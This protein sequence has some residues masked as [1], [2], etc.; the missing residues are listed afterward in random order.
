MRTYV[1][2]REGA[3]REVL[4]VLDDV[5]RAR[6]DAHGL[7]E[8]EAWP[9]DLDRLSELRADLRRAL[10]HHTTENRGMDR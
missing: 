5:Y 2:L 4:A 7:V 6:V 3:A 9:E 8:G 1:E 10:A